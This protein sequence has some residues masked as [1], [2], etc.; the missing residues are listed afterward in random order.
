M[1]IL[2]LLAIAASAYAQVSTADR[3]LQADAPVRELAFLPTGETVAFCA[4]AKVRVWDTQSG[5]LTRTI[6]LEPAV[7]RVTFAPGASRIVT[8]GPDVAMRISDLDGLRNSRELAPAKMRQRGASFSPDGLTLATSGRDKSIRLWELKDGQARL[9]IRGGIGGASAMALSPDGRTL[10]AADDDTNIRVWSTRNGEL[11]RLVDDLPVTTFALAFSPD[12]K[13]LA[14]GGVDRIVYLWDA[15]N[16]KL[17]RKI[18]GQPEMISSLAFSPDGRLLV[19]GGFSEISS[20]EPVSIL[21]RDVVSGK[22][23]R[24]I[25]SAHQVTATEFSPDGKYIATT[26]RDNAVNLWRVPDTK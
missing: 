26:N 4:D 1:R 24:T 3:I 22:V 6:A 21:L 9:A 10:V 19:T 12:G 5:K 11:L 14:S 8:G 25:A 2:A 18:A 13:I 17:L 23:V 7:R 16:W 15:Q 20:K